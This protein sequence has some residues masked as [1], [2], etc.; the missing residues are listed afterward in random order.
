MYGGASGAAALAVDIKKAIRV[1]LLSVMCLLL[2]FGT[3]CLISKKHAQFCLVIKTTLFNKR[4]ESS[5][6]LN[7]QKRIT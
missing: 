4:K 7:K 6:L 3:F 5:F 2:T 1:A